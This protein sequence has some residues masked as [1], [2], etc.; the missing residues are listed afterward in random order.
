MRKYPSKTLSKY[1]FLW[2]FLLLYFQNG[3]G[4]TIIKGS[5]TDS[6]NVPVPYAAI[7]LLDAKDSSLV[8]GG[9]STDSGVYIFDNIKPGSYLIK[10]QVMGY[11]EQYTTIIK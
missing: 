3:V 1:F 6:L 9:L 5:V 7:G 2:L 10:V 8:K 4:Q 11:A